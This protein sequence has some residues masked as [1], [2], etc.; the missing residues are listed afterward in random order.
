MG[1]NHMDVASSQAGAAGHL[2]HECSRQGTQVQLHKQDGLLATP[3][4]LLALHCKYSVI[5]SFPGA[6]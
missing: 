5:I 1:W 3:A 6:F 2:E 4:K